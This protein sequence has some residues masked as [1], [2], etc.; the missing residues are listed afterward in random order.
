MNKDLTELKVETNS[1]GVLMVCVCGKHTN[2]TVPIE[3]LRGVNVCIH[4]VD[5]EDDIIKQW[6]P[7]K[8]STPK[9]SVSG[10][11]L[12]GKVL[13]KLRYVGDSIESYMKNFS[14]SDYE[15]QVHVHIQ[16]MKKV[17]PE[18]GEIWRYDSLSARWGIDCKDL[19]IKISEYLKTKQKETEE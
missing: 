17:C 11:D 9:Q 5:K 7:S 3:Q 2:D 6:Q 19:E 16:P 10:G 15:L 18:S 12:A 13:E 1:G 8:T 4:Y 14:D